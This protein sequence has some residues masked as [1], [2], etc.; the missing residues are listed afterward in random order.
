MSEIMK[1]LD[2]IPDVSFTDEV[3]IDEIKKEMISDFETQY[4]EI[5]G[6]KITL[7]TADPSRLI[8][9]ACALQIYQAFQWVERAGRQD[10]LK[11]SEGEF[12]DNLAALKGIQRLQ[13]SKAKTILRFSLEETKL[14]ATGIPKGT[15]VTGS[16]SNLYFATDTY[17]EIPV[18]S[19]YV[20][21][22]AT[23]ETAG[24][25]GNGYTEG[26]LDTMVDIIPYV[27]QVTNISVTEGGADIED[28]EDLAER[29]YLAPSS[30]SVAGPEDAYRYWAKAFN[31]NIDDIKVSSPTPGEVKICFLLN[32]EL[33]N[34]S[35][36]SGLEEFLQNNNVRPMTDHVK[37][38]AP[39]EENY[40]INLRYFI[41]RS[42]SNQAVTIKI[43][44]EK[45]I[46]DYVAW[47]RKIGRDIN[48][49]E[50]IRRVISAGAKRVEVVEPVYKVVN[51]TTVPKI[52]DNQVQYGGIEDD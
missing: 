34:E 8:L 16:N 26:K 18:D 37:V 24:E 44:V 7:G 45:A 4:E 20:D 10:L 52:Q 17:V 11:Y 47:Q 25:E 50:L 33:P 22:E 3:S 31:Q 38:S 27:Y 49:S 9:Y 40:N 42:D 2:N 48:P 46:N 28:D 21:V 51:E 36:I 15:R 13:A 32:G 35:T 29:A 39:T 30:Y 14:S 1:T 6:D 19:L 5:T 23:C 43:Q 41:N 12:L